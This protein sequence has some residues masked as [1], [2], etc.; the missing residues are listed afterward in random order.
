MKN[1]IVIK[2]GGAVFTS[3]DS[4]I[5]DLVTLQREGKS[6]VVVHG[7]GNLV[8]EWLK[9]QQIATRFVHGERV[10]DEKTLEVVVALL[11]GLANKSM[12]AAINNSGGRAIGISGV[13]GSLIKGKQRSQ[14]LGLVGEVVQVETDILEVLLKA[15][16]IV[17]ISPLSLYAYGRAAGEPHI[18]NIN[19]DPLAGEIAAA[20]KAEE[21]IFLTD[22][23]GVCDESGE[24]LPQL[25][26]PEAEALIASGVAHGGMVP[27]LK[28]GIRALSGAVK[29]RI[30]NGKQ[31]HALVRELAG[32]AEGTT[33]FR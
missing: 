3:E 31:P 8:T 32:Q 27:K 18:L 6:L 28:A 33:I 20:M 21:L 23:A 12:V 4:I 2:I 25:S 7:G 11:G 29:A 14:E 22:V 10:T 16:Y 9:K 26:V 24:L 5:Q 13:D 15:G 17:L 1:V 19:G 30:I